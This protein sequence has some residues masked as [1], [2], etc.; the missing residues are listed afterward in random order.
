MNKKKLW[1]I[2]LF[3]LLVICGTCINII[4]DQQQQSLIASFNKTLALAND[5]EGSG[6]YRYPNNYGKAEFCTLYVY[7]NIRTGA[8]V[9]S[10]D[11]KPSLTAELGWEKT[12]DSGLR[13]KCPK[14]G[15]GCNPYSCQKVPYK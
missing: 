10:E 2:G 7:V 9:E 4:V 3:M 13:D 12:T 15:K 1:I 14:S 5:S 8:K 11:L 6:D